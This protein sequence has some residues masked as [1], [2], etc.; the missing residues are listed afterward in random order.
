MHCSIHRV[1]TNIK[2]HIFTFTILIKDPDCNKKR[3]QF[4]TY[5]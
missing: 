2:A 5:R 3:V 4:Y 1:D